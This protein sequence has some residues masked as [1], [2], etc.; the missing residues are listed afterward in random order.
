MVLP[1]GRALFQDMITAC[2]TNFLRNIV[3]GVTNATKMPERLMFVQNGDASELIYDT[4]KPCQCELNLEWDATNKRI[5]EGHNVLIVNNTAT[6]QLDFVGVAIPPALDLAHELGHFLYALNTPRVAANTVYGSVE[7]RAQADYKTIFAGIPLTKL[8]EFS[9]LWKH[10]I[11]SEAVNILPSASMGV[12]GFL[13]SDGIMIGE[14]LN[15][16][17]AG[18][19]RRPQFFTLTDAAGMATA[20]APPGLNLTNAAGHLLP[21]SSFI[22]FS[23]RN[24]AGFCSV[25]NILTTNAKTQFRALVERLLN[26]ITIPT[27]G[28]VQQYPCTINDLPRI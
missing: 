7:S 24:S 3:N 13:Y 21:S 16:W 4:D 22:R 8:K 10:G 23:H 26:K 20:V 19:H 11:F 6:N 9:D 2:R 17:V 5:I 12:G 27:V 15:V 18:D 25:F 14:A 28:A 1:T